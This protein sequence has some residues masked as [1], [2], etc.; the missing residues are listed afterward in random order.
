MPKRGFFRVMQTISVDEVKDRLEQA[1][2]GARVQV[3]TFQG[4]DHF[5]AVV[6]APQFAGKSLVEQHRM[7]YAA[8]E[9]L[10]GGPMHALALKT[11]ALETD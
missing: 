2:P 6:E 9:G 10:L 1:L 11:R 4:A 7:V 8:L 5:Q 3:G